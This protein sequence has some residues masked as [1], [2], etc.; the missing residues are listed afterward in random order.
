[1][2][3]GCAPSGT[4]FAAL[5]PHAHG[6]PP[7]REVS[8]RPTGDVVGTARGPEEDPNELREPPRSVLGHERTRTGHELQSSVGEV[9]LEPT[10]VFLQEEE[11]VLAPNDQDRTPEIREALR[12]LQ[13]V[14]FRDLLQE[15]RQVP[16]N[17]GIG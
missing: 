4:G 10:G 16:P 6:V 1:M 8:A 12:G 9:A 3:V 15:P 14:P 11:V 5:G 13:R 17:S 2:V 7:S